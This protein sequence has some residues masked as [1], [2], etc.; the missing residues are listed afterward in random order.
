MGT[1]HTM[2]RMPGQSKQMF[3]AEQT[4]LTYPQLSH[5]RQAD[6]ACDPKVLPKP[7]QVL[8]KVALVL[9]AISGHHLAWTVAETCKAA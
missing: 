6:N 5:I 9:Y 7:Q 1:K 8:L 4:G 2:T 3:T